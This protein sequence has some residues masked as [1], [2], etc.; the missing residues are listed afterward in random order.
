MRIALCD[1]ETRF[2]DSFSEIFTPMLAGEDIFKCY[3]NGME[4]LDDNARHPYDLL[5]LDVEMPGLN[6]LDVGSELKSF[7]EQSHIVFVT[8]HPEFAL[9]AFDLRA[10]HYLI[11]PVSSSKLKGCVDEA[12]QRVYSSNKEVFPFTT[13]LGIQ[14]IPV[15]EIVFIE[16][17]WP[18]IYI[19]TFSDTHVSRNSLK[20]AETL[21][22]NKGFFRIHKSYLINLNH[23][24]IVNKTSRR[25]EMLG[26]KELPI[27][28][29]RDIHKFLMELTSIRGG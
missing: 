3:Q 6:G 12:R 29:N 23:V 15:D 18:D 2:I 10:F 8:K 26:N 13:K 24:C 14:Y 16:S 28:K 22:E 25:V 27:G 19:Q 11:K 4:L 9:A 5:F 1:N 7:R 20:S 21:L 17:Y